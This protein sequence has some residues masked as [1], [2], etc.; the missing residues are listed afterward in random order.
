MLK[1]LKTRNDTAFHC[2]LW[3]VAEMLLLEI[4]LANAP[5]FIFLR[6]RSKETFTRN[7]TERL[8][9]KEQFIFCFS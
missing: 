6:Q 4:V 1:T 8:V 7:V 5:V 2:M 3:N 9:Q